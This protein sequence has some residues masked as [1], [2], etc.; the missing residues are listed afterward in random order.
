MSKTSILEKTKTDIEIK[1]PVL[2]KVIILNDD[3]TTVDFVVDVLQNIFDKSY[4]EACEL[5][6]IVHTK[7][8]GLCGTYPYDI[9]ET[10]IKQTR[11]YAKKNDFPLNLICEEI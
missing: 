3:Y 8:S 2:Y 7:G 9:A 10:K 1:D 4:Q 5:T 11:K 6:Q